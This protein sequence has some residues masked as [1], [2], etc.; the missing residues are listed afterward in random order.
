MFEKGQKFK[1]GD[2][3][4]NDIIKGIVDADIDE[5]TRMYIAKWFGA[6]IRHNQMELLQIRVGVANYLTLIINGLI[7]IC[8]NSIKVNAE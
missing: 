6:L 4:F 1:V 3:D 7:Q 2:A 8:N 5:T